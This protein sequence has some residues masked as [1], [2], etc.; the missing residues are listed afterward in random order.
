LGFWEASAVA[1]GVSLGLSAVSLGVL[2]VGYLVEDRMKETALTHV[3]M[4][5]LMLKILEDMAMKMRIES[6]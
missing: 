4:G 6:S 3:T 1:L 2:L 5:Q